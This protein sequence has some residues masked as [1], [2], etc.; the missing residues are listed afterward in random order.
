MTAAAGRIGQVVEIINTISSQIN[1][2]ALNAT[3]EAARAGEAGKGFA[4]V[5]SEV[6]A[7]AN[8]TE[9]ATGEIGMLIAT[10][11]AMTEQSADGIR[12]ISNTIVT[13]N[14]A[15]MVV[16]AAV[17]EQNVVTCDIARSISEAATGSMEVSRNIGGITEAV[18][19]TKGAA[20]E[21]LA[22]ANDLA[23][24]SE[25]LSREINAF[26]DHIKATA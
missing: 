11:R 18:S 4:V 21:V 3:I 6:K 12:N 15:A 19:E 13:I 5:A 20:G 7:L 26:L 23:G 8:Q 14:D 17:E 24:Q 22:A 2:L 25:S 1:L 16:A 10:M 9:K